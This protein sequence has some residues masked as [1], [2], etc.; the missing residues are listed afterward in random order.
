MLQESLS[1]W[2]C[3]HQ[4]CHEMDRMRAQSRSKGPFLPNVH[5]HRASSSRSQCECFGLQNS[6]L[7]TRTLQRLTFRRSQWPRSKVRH[8]AN[9]HNRCSSENTRPGKVSQGPQCLFH[10]AGHGIT[11]AAPSLTHRT[12]KGKATLYTR[13]A[14]SHSHSDGRHIN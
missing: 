4:Q 13:T 7:T 5:S 9:F 12:P 14:L 10:N 2:S 6:C 8:W 3:A 11:H 1:E